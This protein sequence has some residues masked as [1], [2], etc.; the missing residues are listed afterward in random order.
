MSKFASGISAEGG[1]KVAVI[2]DGGGE[3]GVW[4]SGIEGGPLRI[5]LLGNFIRDRIDGEL[6][7]SE[8]WA[9]LIT[10]WRD[11]GSPFSPSVVARGD[12]WEPEGPGVS[13]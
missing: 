10:R 13:S 11:G 3:L 2:L 6:A 8:D 5:E 7:F 12:S 1:D 9:D 4:G